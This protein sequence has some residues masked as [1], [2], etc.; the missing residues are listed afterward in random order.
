MHGLSLGFELCQPGGQLCRLG[1]VQH[2]RNY[3]ETNLEDIRDPQIQM[4]TFC[5]GRGKNYRRFSLG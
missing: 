1:D 4:T 2:L 3:Q 5:K